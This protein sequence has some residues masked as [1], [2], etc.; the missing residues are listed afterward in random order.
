M[1]SHLTIT[2]GFI[3]LFVLELLGLLAT[4]GRVI[5]RLLKRRGKTILLLA[6]GTST[7]MTFQTC[8]DRG[9][10]MLNTVILARM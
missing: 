9:K 5:H 8:K 7:K 4:L 10:A 1:L 2:L 6:I 3:L